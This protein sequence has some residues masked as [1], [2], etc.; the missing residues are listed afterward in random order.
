MKEQEIFEGLKEILHTIKPGVDLE[1]VTMD[2][3]LVFDL[4]I[5]SLSIL[6]LSLAIE[7]KY[8]FTFNGVPPFKTVGDVV[9]FINEKIS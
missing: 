4:G 2:S 1:K 8:G 3:S 5:D 9:R 6:L 7:T